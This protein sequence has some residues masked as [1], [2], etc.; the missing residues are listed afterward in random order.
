MYIHVQVMYMYGD[1]IIARFIVTL[2][3][4][5]NPFPCTYTRTGAFLLAWWADV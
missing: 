1:M 5:A 3:L 4:R 2:T